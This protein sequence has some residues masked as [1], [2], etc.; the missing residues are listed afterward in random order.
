MCQRVSSLGSVRKSVS[1][2]SKVVPK[3]LLLREFWTEPI[4]FCFF[5]EQIYV[6]TRQLVFD[7]R[8]LAIEREKGGLSG[9]RAHTRDLEVEADWCKFRAH[10]TED[11]AV[12]SETTFSEIR[13][14]EKSTC[15]LTNE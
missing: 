2:G 6:G 14:L 1:T 4:M 3:S 12:S 11:E 15:S 8:F 9:R 7:F 13:T 5:Q 10:H